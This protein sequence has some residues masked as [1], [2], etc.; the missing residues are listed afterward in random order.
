MTVIVDPAGTPSIVYR[1]PAMTIV[2]ITA[3]GTTQSDAAQLTRYSAMNVVKVTSDQDARG[4][5]LPAGEE[6][7]YFELHSI[8]GSPSPYYFKVYNSSGGEVTSSST[9]APLRYVGG[10]WRFVAP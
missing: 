8:S 6:G 7:D 9:R 5:K 2:G 3:T 1:D 10:T 4:L